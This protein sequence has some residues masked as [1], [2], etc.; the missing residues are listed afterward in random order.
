LIPD[1]SFMPKYTWQ[2]LVQLM[3]NTIQRCIVFEL[4]MLFCHH[5]DR[6]HCTL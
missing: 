2:E 5:V 4:Y 3:F 6:I 1:Q